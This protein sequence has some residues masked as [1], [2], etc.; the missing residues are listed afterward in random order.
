MVTP[1]V[2][3]IRL[4]LDRLRLVWGY[5]LF[6]GVEFRFVRFPHSQLLV[7]D[8]SCARPWFD[9]L[10][11]IQAEIDSISFDVGFVGAGAATLPLARHMKK[12]G[13]TGIAMG[14]AL[15]LL[16]G[17]RGRRWDLDPRFSRYFNQY[18]IRPLDAETPPKFRSIENGAYW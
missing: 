17:I 14:G 10:K 4:Q 5:D 3:T 8:E 18:W 9:I 11:E 7:N 15:Q 13:R 1:F 6:P 12:I 16:F 2:D